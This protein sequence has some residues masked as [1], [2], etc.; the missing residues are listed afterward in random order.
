MYYKQTPNAQEYRVI[1]G[2][3][4]VTVSGHSRDEALQN[5]RRRLCIEMPRMWD[6]IERLDPRSFQIQPL[7][8]SREVE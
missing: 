1:V 3:A 2:H 6:V 7:N 4:S 5:A 8:P